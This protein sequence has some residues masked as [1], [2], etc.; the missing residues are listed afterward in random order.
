MPLQ[1]TAEQNTL[2]QALVRQ[3]PWASDWEIQR[4]TKLVSSRM[5]SHDFSKG[6]TS[7][8]R[9]D[10]QRMG[11]SIAKIVPPPP[12]IPVQ[13]GRSRLTP[14][15]IRLKAY[16]DARLFGHDRPSSSD[17]SVLFRRFR[18]RLRAVRDVKRSS[19]DENSL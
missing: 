3:I 17:K 1:G 7:Q 9:Q 6:F 15:Y 4:V 13:A 5:D 14:P 18:D 12:S 19:N 11:A 10:A 16:D 2:E 8:M